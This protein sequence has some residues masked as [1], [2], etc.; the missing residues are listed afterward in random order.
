MTTDKRRW[1][2][3]IAGIAAAVLCLLLARTSLLEGGCLQIVVVALDRLSIVGWTALILAAS[4]SL[5]CRLLQALGLKPDGA[6][7]TALFGLG[8]GL[9]ALSLLM[10][11]LGVLGLVPKL[12]LVVLLMGMILM[13]LRDLGA[14]LRA[15]PDA[16]T[17]ARR[18]SWFRLTLWAVLTLFLLMNLTRAF[19]PPSDYD[20]LE[21]HAAAPAAYDRADRVFFIRD[22][23]YANFPQNVEMLHF[24]GMRLTGSPDRGILVGQML[25]AAMGLLAALAL[26]TMLAGI[27][28]KEV[29]DAG[30]LIF[31][32]WPGATIYSGVPFVELPLIFYGTLAVWGLLWSWRRKRTRPGARGWV[33]LSAIATGMALG[34]KYTAALLIF[35]PVGAWLLVLGPLGGAGLKET[36]R[37]AAIYAGIALLVFSPW[38][39]RNF[40][41]TRNPVYPLLYKVF[42]GTT[43]DAEKDVRWT[44]AHSPRDRSWG[45]LTEKAREVVFRC[46]GQLSEWKAS[47]LM[48]V[49]IPLIWLVGR[50]TRGIALFLA[51]HALAL[52]LLWFIFT[53]QNARFLEAGVPILAALSALGLGAA[54]GSKY[55]SGLRVI[56][57]LLLLFAPSRW[58]NYVNVERSLGVALG[59][60]SRDQ[61]FADPAKTGFQRG[62]AA[63]KF[64]NDEK[65]LPPGAKILFLG[66]ARTFYCRRDHVA[67]TVFDSN[68]LEEIVGRS[69][70]PDDVRYFLEAADITHVYVDTSH[71][72][73]LQ[74]SYRYPY[75]GRERLGMLD[76][77]NWPLFAGF[78]KEHLQLVGTFAGFGAERFAWAEWGEFV[79]RY[80]REGGQRIPPGGHIIALYAL[81]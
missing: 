15:I 70:K 55:A 4:L 72:F 43:W 42:G 75:E 47:L 18:A 49:F 8:L 61:Y 58:V 21:Y 10:L 81:R 33:M 67:S 12:L 48:V 40:V 13:G 34:V 27:A 6:G 77:F 3:A 63:M 26:R 60:V 32:S 46:D 68:L 1:I 7:A 22:N 20:S 14:I 69:P 73:R 50:R 79:E 24:L 44:T 53:Q 38:L 17:R 51:V 36:A 19:E 52:F 54:L 80:V 78:A 62:Y 71:L 76:G 39:V 57:I 11:G 56:F 41:N 2:K 23:V 45:A 65:N 31:Y 66:E 30:A 37:R 64:V 16:L 25:G 29:G 5:G 59:A 74:E 28:G 35:V 9:G